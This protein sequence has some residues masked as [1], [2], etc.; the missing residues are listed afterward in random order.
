[1]PASQL[2]VT[3]HHGCFIY[4]IALVGRTMFWIKRVYY[5]NVSIPTRA[6]WWII[7]HQPCTI[8][9]QY[10]NSGSLGT[11]PYSYTQPSVLCLES[12]V[13][14]DCRKLLAR[15]EFV[16]VPSTHPCHLF[17]ACVFAVPKVHTT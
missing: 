8:P 5:R 13:D 6:A 4:E 1:M 2:D 10:L 7:I 9:W 14:E 16:T 11:M 17:H 15:K 3:F 12:P